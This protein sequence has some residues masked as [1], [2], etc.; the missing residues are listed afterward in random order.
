[1][2]YYR[3]VVEAEK[4]KEA[5]SFMASGSEDE[6]E[7]EKEEE[8]PLPEL[9][10][11]F[12]RPED[13]PRNAQNRQNFYNYTL[14]AMDG[15]VSDRLAARM[16]TGVTKRLSFYVGFNNHFCRTFD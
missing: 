8:E 4:E 13:L 5:A 15:G 12:F 7:E 2:Q 6:V 11:L 3:N 14:M 16:A 10:D 1:M 9:E